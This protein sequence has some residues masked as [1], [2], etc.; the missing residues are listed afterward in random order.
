MWANTQRDGRP[1]EHRW[2]SLRKFIIPLRAPRCEVW[3]MPTNRVLCSKAVNTG[4][5]CTMQNSGANLTLRPSLALSYID[6]VTAQHSII[7]RRQPNFAALS[8]GVTYIRRAAITL[9]IGPHSSSVFFFLSS[10]NLSRLR[11]DR[12]RPYFHTR[13]DLSA[14]LG[15]RSET[16][17]T[18]LAGNTGRKKSP[19]VH[20]HTTLSGYIFAIRHISTIGKKFVKQ[21]YLLHMSSQYRELRPTSG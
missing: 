10:P 18:R 14:N 20:H 15:C 21:Q 19:S 17:C 5:F 7:S 9:R 2:R 16:C 3:P 11:L 1:A 4:E 12:C 8:R 6:S 13:C